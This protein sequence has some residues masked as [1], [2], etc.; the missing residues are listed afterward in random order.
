MVYGEI[1]GC[2]MVIFGCMMGICVCMMGILGYMWM[3]DG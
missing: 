1:T 2:I 3:Y